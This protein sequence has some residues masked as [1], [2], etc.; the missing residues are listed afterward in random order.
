MKISAKM[1]AE[2]RARTGAGMMDCKKA[3]TE[4]DGDVDQA[5]QLLREQGLRASELKSSREA[6]E[7]I[8]VSY[9][10]PGNR[11]GAMVEINCE[12]DFVA[13]TDVFQDLAKN[14]AMQIAASKPRYLERKEVPQEVIDS[15]KAILKQ[16]DDIQGNPDHIIGRIVEGRLDKFYTE[17]CLLEQTFIRDNDKTLDQIVKESIAQLGEN[18]VINR[19]AL[20]VLGQS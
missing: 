19:F 10:H 6:S 15:E 2:L 1:V 16:Q 13:R 18:I 11:I 7:G 8:I 4:V 17:V 3:L 5:I 20:Y 14:I 12:T 9:I